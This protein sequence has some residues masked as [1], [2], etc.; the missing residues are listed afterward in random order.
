MCGI[1]GYW[2]SP[3]G[4]HLLPA[5][6]K[7]ADAIAHRGPDDSGEWCDTQASIALAHRRLSVIDTSSAGHQPMASSNGRYVMVYN[8]EIY[9]HLDFRNELDSA[10]RRRGWVGHSDTETLIEAIAH[11]GIETALGKCNGMFAFALWDREQRTL[12]LAR[13]RMGE[14]PL[15]FGCVNGTF[16]FGSELKALR[17]HPLW[18]ADIDRNALALYFRFQYVPA[19]YAIF[20]NINKLRPGHLLTVTW[21]S[22]PQWSE[23][24][25]W[26]IEKQA[27]LGLTEHNAA[28]AEERVDELHNLL[29]DAV[30]KRMIADV[31]LGAF[32]SG[33]Y[34]SSLVVALMQKHSHRAVRTF[35]IGFDE[36][37]YNEAPYAKRVA[38]HLGTQHEE[39]YVTASD[40]LEV[41]PQLSTI[42][43][44]PFGDSSQVPTY[45]VSALASKQLTVALTG[46][47]GDESFYGY[48]RYRRS[49]AQ[50][51]S[52]SKYPHS[53]RKVAAALLRATPRS[54]LG[55]VMQAVRSGY[56]LTGLSET[57]QYLHDVIAYADPRLAYRARIS[58]SHNPG[59]LVLG[60]NPA[61]TVFDKAC[62]SPT[63][64]MMQLLDMQSYLPDDILVKVDRAS[65]ARSLETRAPLLDHRLVEL[66]LRI[67]SAMQLD[68]GSGKYLLKQIA[69]RY[70]PEHLLDR[71][72]TGF[73]VPIDAWLRGPLRSWAE[74]LLNK[75]RLTNEGYL[76]PDLVWA[77]W[78]E[79][80]NGSRN[81][82]YQLWDLLMFQSWLESYG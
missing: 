69:H 65:M 70:L 61:P 27:R 80:Q 37:D 2:G 40:A 82:Q 25:Y 12:T 11:W 1:A 17:Q 31:P 4:E 7:M 24:V 32:L 9:N 28:S 54:L 78:L 63:A 75:T 51:K 36:H 45:L 64:A 44:E 47:G 14:K 33:G 5:A 16:L 22:G 13:D 21:D 39:L 34:D 20:Q 53:M 77:R 72:K 60:S 35:T 6:R 42:W 67:P 26:D 81:W 66:A 58:H 59:A 57:L 46:D 73:G 52:V 41:V 10:H 49:E 71:P 29:D 8:G 55:S 62:D 74:N 23:T 30:A 18:Q 76:Q 56:G 38:Q 43:C 79:H 15:Y 3:G 19:P 48:T 50:W 68:R